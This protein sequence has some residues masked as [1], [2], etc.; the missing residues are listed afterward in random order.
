MNEL[1]SPAELTLNSFLFQ[2]GKVMV[3][4]DNV[5]NYG[6][7]IGLVHINVL[8]VEEL[9]ETKLLF[10][11]VEGVVE[12]E[13]GFGFRHFVVLDQFGAMLV[14]DCV[15]SETVSPRRCKV[16]DVDVVVACRL[17]LTPKQYSKITL[18]L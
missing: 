3:I 8:S 1:S 18:H 10:S 17:H 7:F 12:I 4:G 13:H 16:A 15:A 5:S 2:F 11:H 6:L 9:G 14:D